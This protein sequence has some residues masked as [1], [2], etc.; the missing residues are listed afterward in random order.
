M[1]WRK[2]NE[3]ISKISTNIIVII[4]TLHRMHI[5][6]SVLKMK[7]KE[8]HYLLIEW[9]AC[10]HLTQF[11][12][13][14]KRLSDGR[15]IKDRYIY[16]YIVCLR[17]WMVFISEVNE[18]LSFWLNMNSYSIFIGIQQTRVHAHSRQTLFAIYR[19]ESA[20]HINEWNTLCL[21]GC[22]H[23]F[24]VIADLSQHHRSHFC[25]R[26]SIK[27]AVS[28]PMTKAINSHRQITSEVAVEAVGFSLAFRSSYARKSMDPD[29]RIVWMDISASM[30]LNQKQQEANARIRETALL[31]Y[32]FVNVDCVCVSW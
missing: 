30:S 8:H 11:V 29:E 13:C 1:E 4:R 7:I 31:E 25:Y 23:S 20:N 21:S 12:I 14:N 19:P 3:L 32:I 22:M 26:G 2:I 17:G 10:L 5:Y 24:N 18:L 9:A 28:W 16:L 27:C 15:R 6:I